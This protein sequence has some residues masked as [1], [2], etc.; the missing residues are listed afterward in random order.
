MKKMKNIQKKK[1]LKLKLN[2]K[3]HLEK[4]MMKKKNNNEHNNNEEYISF[5]GDSED[6][7]KKIKLI[8]K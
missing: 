2:W 4:I 8:Y 1:I 6:V 7:K 3:F 5:I